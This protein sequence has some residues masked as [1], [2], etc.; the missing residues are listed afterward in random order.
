MSIE[1]SQVVRGAFRV[2]TRFRAAV[3]ELSRA[4]WELE[5]EPRMLQP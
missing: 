3:L 2:E 5:N 1:T 4:H